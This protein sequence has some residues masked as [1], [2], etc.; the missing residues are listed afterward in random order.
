M[1]YA[2]ETHSLDLASNAT[3]KNKYLHGWDCDRLSVLDFIAISLVKIL[4]NAGPFWA[5]ADP[6]EDVI[7]RIRRLKKEQST[8]DTTASFPILEPP[9]KRVWMSIV[10]FQSLSALSPVHEIGIEDARS[11]SESTKLQ[12]WREELDY[13]KSKKAE[14]LENQEYRDKYIALK[15]K[16]IVDSDVDNFDLV[17]RIRAKY[18]E[19]VVLI[20]KVTKDVRQLKLRSP[21]ISR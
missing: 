4:N 18:P 9:S 6:D 15:D 3:E 12:K 7:Q 21:K 17:R 1:N 14:W 16:M 19:E 5:N 8:S 13:F 11:E 2:M 20:A 10:G